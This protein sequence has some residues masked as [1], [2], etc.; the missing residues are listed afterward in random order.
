LEEKQLLKNKYKLSDATIFYAGRLAIEKHIDVIIKAI[1]LVIKEFPKINFAITG[2][3]NSKEDLQ[4]LAEK[5]GIKNQIKFFGRVDDGAIIEIFKASDIFAIMS[6]AET[7][8]ISLMKAMAVGLP[9]IVADARALPTHINNQNGF[10]VPVGDEIILAEKIKELL[11]DSS[12]C[13]S[14]GQGG[15]SHV[16]QFSSDKVSMKWE[17]IFKNFSKK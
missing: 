14:L 17:E 11:R 7:Q 6:T 4:N 15:I 1:A 8:S 10:V 3:G 2:H 5:L 16:K 13:Y 9:S 12:L